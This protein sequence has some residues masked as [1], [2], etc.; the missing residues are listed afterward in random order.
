MINFYHR[1]IP[2]CSETAKPLFELLSKKTLKWTQSCQLAFEDLKKTLVDPKVL[3]YPDRSKDASPLL[4]FVDASDIGAGACLAQ[5]Q[6]GKE[7]PIAFI[8]TTFSQAESKYSTTEREVAA[9]R[10]AVKSLKPFLYGIKVYIHTDHNRLLFLNNMTLVNQRVARTLEEIN[11]I[12]YE[13][14][15]IPGKKNVVA[16]ALSRSLPQSEIDNTQCFQT[17]IPPGYVVLTMP[18]G[19]DS[20]F[21]CFSSWLTGS[22]DQHLQISELV[23]NELL[24]N[25]TRYHLPTGKGSRITKQLKLLKYPGQ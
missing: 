18:G 19:G 23:T 8:S 4:L 5:V 17:E 15:Y 9:I 7:H 14:R 10:W 25:R 3:S 11:D 1:H 24:E 12:D 16:D 22:L 13:L 20:L 2:Q 6:Q 21:Q